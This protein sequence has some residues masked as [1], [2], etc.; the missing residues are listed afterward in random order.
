MVRKYTFFFQNE[1]V[2][3]Q[4]GDFAAHNT[5]TNTISFLRGCERI[6]T[7]SGDDKIRIEP[8]DGDDIPLIIENITGLTPMMKDENGDI[9][10]YE[11]FEHKLQ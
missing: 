1:R 7:G 11:L 10:I 4:N 5:D 6:Y 9:V 3:F 8:E 2:M